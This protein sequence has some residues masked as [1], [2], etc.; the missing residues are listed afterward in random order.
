MDVSAEVTGIVIFSMVV[1]GV[2]V[3]TAVVG[4]MVV[5]STFVCAAFVFPP[6]FT[7]DTVV[8]TVV[9]GIELFTP[10]VTDN[11]LVSAIVSTFTSVVRLTVEY[12]MGLS[13]IPR[14]VVSV[15][16]TGAV[17]GF[18][19]VMCDSA[20]VKRF[21]FVSAVVVGVVVVGKPE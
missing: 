20:V 2:F 4:S 5:V 16:V 13:S 14:G 21:C 7:G 6:V 15:V 12:A 3:V 19:A 17:V 1:T 8:G 10:V 18:V 9:S 11:V